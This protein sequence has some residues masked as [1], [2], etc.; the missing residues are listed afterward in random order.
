MSWIMIVLLAATAYLILVPVLTYLAARRQL[1]RPID[2]EL[3]DS[4]S[5]DRLLY[6]YSDKC[7]P[8]RHMTPIVD[9]LAETNTQVVKVDVLADKETAR[10]FHIR[11]T[12]TT[13]LVKENRIL[14]IALGSKTQTQLE[15]LLRRL[16]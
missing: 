13:V 2:S 9:Q 14:D 16:L 7:G 5:G 15:K 1:G 6:F 3:P 4:V 8:C 10:R 11:A 12:P